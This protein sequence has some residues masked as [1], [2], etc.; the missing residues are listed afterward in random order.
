MGLYEV[1]A[2]LNFEDEA[3]EVLLTSQVYFV[4]YLVERGFISKIKVED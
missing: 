2:K 1:L 4:M 3:N